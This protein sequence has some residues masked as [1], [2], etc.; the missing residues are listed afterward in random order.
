MPVLLFD[1]MIESRIGIEYRGYRA[2]LEEAGKRWRI[3]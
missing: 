1:G 2:E 3:L